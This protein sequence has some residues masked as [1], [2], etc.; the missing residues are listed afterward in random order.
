MVAATPEGD[1]SRKMVNVAASK[2]SADKTVADL[3]AHAQV[4]ASRIHVCIVV[5][6]QRDIS[7]IENKPFFRLGQQGDGDCSSN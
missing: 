5:Y 7:K 2:V 6:I 1:I 3:A 4:R